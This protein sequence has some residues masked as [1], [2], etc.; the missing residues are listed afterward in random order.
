VWVVSVG[1]V[2][3]IVL[4]DWRY[5]SGGG[6]SGEARGVSCFDP[7]TV[8]EIH[9]NQNPRL[10]PHAPVFGG[11][12]GKLIQYVRCNGCGEREALFSTPVR[13]GT[14]IVHKVHYFRR[15][16]KCNSWDMEVV[17]EITNAERVADG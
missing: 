13:A 11:V 15:C 12:P 9:V 17:A 2:C 8:S 4:S 16:D 7:T 5:S 3:G 6:I 1:V 14:F 10:D